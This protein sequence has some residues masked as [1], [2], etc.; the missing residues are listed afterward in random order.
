[1]LATVA[2][3]I[4]AGAVADPMS[5]VNRTCSGSGWGAERRAGHDVGE[6]LR[7]GLP[8]GSLPVWNRPASRIIVGL[9]NS[10]KRPSPAMADVKV[11]TKTK[12]GDGGRWT[13]SA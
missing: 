5:R 4:T 12:P 1:M 3:P 6:R 10:R 8:L 7:V 13:R 11:S 9:K 2:P